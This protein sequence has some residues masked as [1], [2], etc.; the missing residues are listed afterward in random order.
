VRQLL[1]RKFL[2]ASLTLVAAFVLA[3]R[4][5]LTGDFAIIASVVNGAFTAA[6]TLITRKSLAAG[7]T[8]TG[9][10]EQGAK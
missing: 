10:N 3:L 7:I 6:D 5:Q 9:R 1:G 2:V 8:A 4:G